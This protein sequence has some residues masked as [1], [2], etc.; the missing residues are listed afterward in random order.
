MIKNN[1]LINKLHLATNKA[2]RILSVVIKIKKKKDLVITRIELYLNSIEKETSIQQEREILI[3][4]FLIFFY[5]HF[6]LSFMG[7][8]IS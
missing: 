1:N 8:W 5:L 3:L 6:Y 4:L 2:G 7:V